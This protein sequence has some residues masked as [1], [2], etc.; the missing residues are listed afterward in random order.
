VPVREEKTKTTQAEAHGISPALV[1]LMAV[2][3]AI[4]VGN[5]YYVQPLLN[6]VAHTLHTSEAAASLLVTASQL[7]YAAGLLFIVPAGDITRRRP[8]LTSLLIVC[9][10]ALVGCTFAP[11]LPALDAFVLLTG[12]TSVVVQMLV[13][14]AATLASDSE[15][16]KVIGTLMGGLL[17]GILLSRTF[18]G[19]VAQ[20]AGWRAVYGV[21]AVLIAI[22]ALAL[23]RALPDH[24]R[25]LTISY[26]E[27]MRGVF[28]VARAEPILRWRSLI[29]AC[30][31]G[32]FGCFWTTVTFLLSSP[33]YGF[34]QLEI[35]VFALVGAAGATT[36]MTGGRFLDARPH[37][38][39]W[40]TGGALALL[41]LSYVPIGLAGAHLG[42]L[43]LF[44]LII[45][46]LVMD[47]CVQ[48]AHVTNQS[49]IYD[50]LP[51]AR[52][53]LT[54]VYVTTM[55][56]GGAVGSAVGAQA[57]AHWGWTGATLVAALFPAL[58]LLCWLATG[59]HERR[60]PARV[61]A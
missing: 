52:S 2:T 3:C 5:L 10:L 32:T 17:I 29:A 9:A 11:S 36:A 28:D 34:S 57:Y 60:Q 59:R 21:A 45:G 49:I 50:L 37:L 58:G 53:R 43:G 56:A 46:V 31:F 26:R 38:R 24:P 18:A 55:F 48:G 40:I 4:T 44:L 25:Q 6:S 35:G 42:G 15:R 51:E 33:Q 23:R 1:R 47:A 54:T 39:W 13:P 16:S 20:F 30:G 7:G 41:V 61:Q 22:N 8:L 19:V 27:Q 12:I 14:Y